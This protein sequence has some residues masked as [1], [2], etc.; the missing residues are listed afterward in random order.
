MSAF[1]HRHLTGPFDIV[2]D[3]HGCARE[4]LELLGRLGYAIDLAGAQVTSAPSGRRVVFVGDLVD[5]GPASPDVWRIVLALDAAG[6][7]HAVPG[8]H[9]VKF[10]RWLHGHAVHPTHGLDQTIAQFEMAPFAL[11]ERVAAFIDRLPDYLWLDGGRLVVAHA[12]I[13]EPM[14]GG[15]DGK[16][17]NFCIYGDTDGR[18][19]SDGL[20]IR[21]NWAAGYRGEATIVYGHIPVEHPTWLGNTVCIDTGC[22]FGGALTALRWPERETVSVPAGATYW[23]RARPPGLPPP[24]PPRA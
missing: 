4:L 15:S 19:D 13:L 11:R 14:I 7:V 18:L 17:R 9:D 10:R 12:G 2:G 3:V 1:D 5:R 24:R 6:L 20:V 23:Q 21:Y 16:T 22:C 8:N